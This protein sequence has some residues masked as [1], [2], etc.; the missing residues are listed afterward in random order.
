MKKEIHPTYYEAK[1]SCACGNVI[2]VG[3]TVKQLSTE[4]CAKCHPFFTGKQKHMDTTGRVEKFNKKYQKFL[5]TQKT[6]G[7]AEG[8]TEEKET[9]KEEKAKQPKKESKKKKQF[10]LCKQR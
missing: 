9:V 6:E 10:N 2:E 4:V 8:K 7:S 3:S 1:I 5:S